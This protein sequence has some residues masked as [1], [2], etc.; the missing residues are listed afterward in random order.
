[1]LTYE[2]HPVWI[3]GVFRF[4]DE[5]DASK[6]RKGAYGMA[7]QVLRMVE[8]DAPIPEPMVSITMDGALILKWGIRGGML[9]I[10]FDS[11]HRFVYRFSGVDWDTGVTHI[12][13]DFADHIRTVFRLVF[14]AN[15]VTMGGMLDALKEGGCD[16]KD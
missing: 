14:R 6:F 5:H 12:Y 2:T 13:S 15:I 9:V 8:S 4:L 1:M 3:R 16:A 10:R 11:S 7:K